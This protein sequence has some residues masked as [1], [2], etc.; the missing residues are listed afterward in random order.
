MI[1]GRRLRV[2]AFLT[3]ETV[4]L[5][6]R[7]KEYL[8]AAVLVGPFVAIYGTL[9]VWPAIQMVLLSFT[10]APLIGSGDWVGINN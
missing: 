4:M 1:L 6:D 5:R 2:P 10:D 8:T 9:F 7:R 3:E